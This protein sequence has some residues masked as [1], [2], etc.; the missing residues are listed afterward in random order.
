MFDD[1]LDLNH[2]AQ[3]Q[4]DDAGEEQHGCNPLQTVLADECR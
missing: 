3:E 2:H 4:G 1:A